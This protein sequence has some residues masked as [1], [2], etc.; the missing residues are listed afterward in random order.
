MNK[1]K[2]PIKNAHQQPVSD[3]S[4]L[5]Q[6]FQSQK[7]GNGSKVIDYTILPEDPCYCVVTAIHNVLDCHKRLGTHDSYPLAIYKLNKNCNYCSFFVAR[8]VK[9]VLK[10]ADWR[11]NY[12][13]VPKLEAKL[14][15]T[16]HSICIGVC[17]LLYSQNASDD[18]FQA[19][20]QWISNK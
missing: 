11:V 10:E 4:A 19:R 2:R 12:P 1:Q 14:N 16:C 15:F 8:G 9:W 5:Q 3:L 18:T 7:N 17:A 6:I 20:L 13:D